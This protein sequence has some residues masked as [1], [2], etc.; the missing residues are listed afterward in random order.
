MT[1]RGAMP[2]GRY[3]G[4]PIEEIPGDYL[5][6]LLDTVELRPW[7]RGAVHRELDHRAGRCHE[8][9]GSSAPLP[10]SPGIRIRQ[11]QLP[12]ARRLIDAGY[13]ALA[14]KI[15]PDVDGDFRQMQA[16]NAL[17][18]SLRAQIDVLER[19]GLLAAEGAQ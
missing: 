10:A 7:L 1:W 9:R 18:E 5:A 14:K 4:C 3:R 8:D 2:F 16:L 11:E 15:H 12:L 6:W 17:A 19:A 13:R